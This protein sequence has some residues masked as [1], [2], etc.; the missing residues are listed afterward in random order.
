MV[1][2]S[3]AP[4]HRRLP[5]IVLGILLT[6]ASPW[7]VSLARAATTATFANA[8]YIRILDNAAAT[9][10]PSPIVVSG[11]SDTVTK[12]TVTISGMSHTFPSDIDV[13]L[14]GPAG[15]K[16]L[17]MSDAGGSLDI[18]GVTLTFDD[19]AASS[20]TQLGQIV[21]GTFKTTNFDTVSD[22]FPAPAPAGPYSSVLSV[23]NGINPNGTWNL[24]VRDDVGGDAGEIALGWS[25][26]FVSTGS[27][28]P[29]QPFPRTTRVSVSSGGALGN[30]Q[31]FLP[32]ISGDGNIVVFDSFAT[33]LASP[34]FS[35]VNSIYVRNRATSIT[36][37]VSVGPGPVQGNGGSTG[38][39]SFFPQVSSD[40]RFVVFY[41]YSDNLLGPGID[42]NGFA[43]VFIYD[44]NSATVSRVSVGTGSPGAQ[45]NH[46]SESH[47]TSPS[48]S[49][50]GR[51]V[52]FRSLA[53]NLVG[54]GCTVFGDPQIFVRDRLLNTTICASVNNAGARSLGT[55]LNEPKI[56]ADG[57]FV[58]F[59][60]NATNLS[61]ACTNGL[62]HIYLRDTITNTTE[63]ISISTGGVQGDNFSIEPRISATG[64]FVAFQSGATNL[65]APCT[66]GKFHIYVRDRLVNTTTCMTINLDGAPGDGDSLEPYLSADGLFVLYSSKATNLALPCNNG[67]SQILLFHRITGI[68]RCASVATDDSPGNG[69]SNYP[70]ISA[71]GRFVAFYSDA[72]NLSPGDTNGTDDIFVTDMKIPYPQQ[73]F[74]FD[75]DARADLGVYRTPSALWLIRRSTDAGLT[76]VPWGSPPLIDSPVAG[77]FDGDGK[78]DIAVYRGATG[79]WF[80]RR[81][82]DAGLIA[83]AWGSP[84]L[85]DFPVPA[86]YD[87][88]GMTD[89][90]VYRLTTGEFFIRRSS[91]GGLVQSPWGMAGLDVPVPADYD[92]DGKADLAVYRTSNGLWLIRRSSDGGT[93]QIFWGA[94]VLGDAPLAAD[95][96]GDGKADLA[97]YRRSNG[98]WLIRRSTDGGLAQVF[99]GAP[100]LA[101]V[102]VPADYDGDGKTDLAVFRASNGLWL[103]RRSSD[104]GLTQIFWGAPVLGD[105]ALPRRF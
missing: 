15:Q 5:P 47:F 32:A 40:G 85:V 54:A 53:S 58:T 3:G 10:Y 18:S 35:G 96:D 78:A 6:S 103:I 52:A 31:S 93:T 36:T 65:A 92:G 80:I 42:T 38:E 57:R 39:G 97:V 37:C 67:I 49:G 105:V 81:S 41:S 24:F 44:R 104:G 27:K 43:D 19:D 86:D 95:Y 8:S 20:L 90:A 22:A 2:S 74:D 9:L 101:D 46:D 60:T 77:D 29:P 87:G 14:V 84:P 11:V 51:F 33:N 63:C 48:V 102:P 1:A 30:A 25:L 56:S 50:D 75:G 64:R 100:V 45:G 26:T 76:Q 79:E 72:T 98:L 61:A 71:D 17:L 69:G 89:L 99:W 73:A 4:A 28:L 55:S 70:K 62:T 68:T 21:S 13:L 59:R 88:D 82:S 83:I 34:C 94:P 7:T 12:V 66:N 23:F 91:D 16:V